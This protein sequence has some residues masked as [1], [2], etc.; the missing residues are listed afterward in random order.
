M[1]TYIVQEFYLLIAIAEIVYDFGVDELY[2][3]YIG[4]LAL[5]KLR[6]NNGYKTGKYKKY[7]SEDKED[8]DYLVELVKDEDSSLITVDSIY[9]KLEDK[10]KTVK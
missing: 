1:Q 2:K 10:Y 7:W 9:A 8:N 5:N 3:M 6:Q 4:K